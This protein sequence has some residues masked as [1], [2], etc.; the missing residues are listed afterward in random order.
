MLMC[1]F[2]D[3]LLYFTG[4]FY[5][6]ILNR[7]VNAAVHFAFAFIVCGLLLSIVFATFMGYFFSVVRVFTFIL[8]NQHAYSFVTAHALLIFVCQ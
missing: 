3:V 4:H 8:F 7:F 5:R 6:F 1:Y 2:V